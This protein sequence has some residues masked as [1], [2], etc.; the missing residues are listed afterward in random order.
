[1]GLFDVEIEVG[2]AAGTTF[3]RLSVAVDTGSLYTVIPRP[4]LE[5]LGVRPYD[6][7]RFKL[8]DGTVRR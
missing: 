5:R 2:D 1:M 7:A 3:E 6:T 4:L 8:A